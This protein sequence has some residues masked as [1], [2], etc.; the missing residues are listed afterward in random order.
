VKV[1]TF[2]EIEAEFRARVARD[3]CCNLATIDAQQRP[4]SRVVQ[5]LWEGLMCWLL[6]DRTTPKAQ[7]I[8]QHRYVSLAYVGDTSKP[9]YVECRAEWIE[10]AAEKRRVWVLFKDTAKFG[11]DPTPFYKRAD[12]PHLGL[13]K[14]TPW[15]IQIDNS[16]GEIYIWEA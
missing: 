8:E 11:Y 14:L 6:T 1:K 5:P 9:L 7:H 3:I 16:P 13:L 10:D 15:R 12:H 2:S 4:R